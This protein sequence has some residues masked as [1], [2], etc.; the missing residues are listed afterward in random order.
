MKKSW[1]KRISAV[2]RNTK[3]LFSEQLFDDWIAK[4]WGDRRPRDFLAVLDE[5]PQE[6]RL[7]CILRGLKEMRAAYDQEQAIKPPTTLKDPAGCI[8]QPS[9]ATA[10]II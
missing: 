2:E 5:V 1:D 9:I 8:A 10:K 3:S 7:A 6:F 4:N